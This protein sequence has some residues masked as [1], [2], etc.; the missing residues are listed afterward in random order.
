[1]DVVGKTDFFQHNGSF[2]TVGCGKGVEVD[3]K[4]GSW[5]GVISNFKWQIA[6]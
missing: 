2:A 1:M 4:F 5:K 3:H 6:N